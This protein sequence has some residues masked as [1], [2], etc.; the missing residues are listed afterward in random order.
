MSSAQIVP[1]VPDKEV[2]EVYLDSSGMLHSADPPW[3][4][5]QLAA[6]IH[7]LTLL[8]PFPNPICL[9][10]VISKSVPFKMDF[11]ER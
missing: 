8:S 4:G 5:T 3:R 2:T 10:E 6:V 11:L 9:I 1:S 7:H